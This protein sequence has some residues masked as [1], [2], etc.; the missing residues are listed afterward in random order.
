ML[1]SDDVT[2]FGKEA[3]L[4][5]SFNMPFVNDRED[6]KVVNDLINALGLTQGSSHN[7]FGLFK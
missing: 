3:G 2:T 6:S 5:I 1:T 4:N 7:I